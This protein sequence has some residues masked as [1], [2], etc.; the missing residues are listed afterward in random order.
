MVQKGFRGVLASNTVR[1]CDFA[2]ESRVVRDVKRANTGRTLHEDISAEGML[3]SI[4]LPV[5]Y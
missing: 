4:V 5:A 3:L 1:F 2:K